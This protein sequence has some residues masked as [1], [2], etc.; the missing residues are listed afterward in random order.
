MKVCVLL[1]DYS[2]STVD[3]QHY[4]PP[5][6]L[7]PLIPEHDVD[8]VFL[9]KLTTYR[10]LKDLRKSGYHIFVNLCEGY[11]DWEVPSIDVPYSLELLDVPFT[12]PPS[13]LYDPPKALMKYVAYCEGVDIPPSAVVR[14]TD[15]LSDAVANLRYPMFIKPAKAGDS[16]GIDDDSVVQDYAS[17]ETRVALLLPEFDEVLI[18]EYI[19]GREFTVLVVAN[20]TTEGT[21]TVLTP[22]EYRFPE[23]RRFKTY[24]LKTSELH[25]DANLPCDDPDI[26]LRLREAAERI[27]IAFSGEGY[28]RMDFRL[29][30]DGR[31]FFLEV[32]FTSSVFYTNGYEGSAD[33]ILRFDG[34]GQSGFLRHIIAEGINRHARKRKPYIMKGDAIAGYG[35]YAARELHEGSLIFRGEERSQRIV[36]RRHVDQHWSAAAKKVFREYAYPISREVFIL[37]DREPDAW[38][39]QNHSCDPNTGYDGLN[40]IALRPIAPG[41]ELTLDYA[42]FL[43]E[44][45]EPFECRC[46]SAQCRGRII[47]TT[48]NSV[49]MR[50]TRFGRSDEFA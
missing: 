19:P 7:S 6:N 14:S 41:E 35:I 29:H 8:H 31:L 15:A 42:N 47:G 27:F 10:Q 17:L 26:G 16:L 36:T 28:A 25:P 40:V 23:D 39:P 38:A 22:I 43:D 2:P 45:A 4:D 5:R 30:P 12:G 1:P 9:N 34:I 20:A 37:W 33:Y 3:Y 13:R 21:C 50:E 18:E 32:N 49:T 11:L 48:G 46:G 24:A 44:R